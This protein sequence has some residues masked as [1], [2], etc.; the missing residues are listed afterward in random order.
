MAGDKKNEGL[1]RRA[2]LTGATATAFVFGCSKEPEKQLTLPP[3]DG[4]FISPEEAKQLY[5]S[6]KEDVKKKL[7]V[8]KARGKPL[9]IFMLEGHDSDNSLAYNIMMLNIAK[10]L[11][12]GNVLIEN[13]EQ[14]LTILRDPKESSRYQF[15]DPKAD[16]HFR[17]L[18][19]EADKLRLNVKGID[20]RFPD[21]AS[22][23]TAMRGHFAKALGEIIHRKYTVKN[24]NLV[25]QAAPE[26][27]FLQNASY[28]IE[29]EFNPPV[30]MTPGGRNWQEFGNYI[31]QA[32]G[33]M[34]DA[35]REERDKMM[36]DSIKRSGAALVIIGKNH[37]VSLISPLR[38]SGEIDIAIS[39]ADIAAE[40]RYLS[41]PAVSPKQREALAW[42]N[43]PKNAL[44]LDGKD[45]NPKGLPVFI[46][47]VI[48]RAN[49]T[50]VVR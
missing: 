6:L 14:T 26:D 4:N 18:L 1:S 34:A 12:I 7:E 22:M 21:A 11:G 19:Q 20:N 40:N 47:T 29:G 39:A 45:F 5:I 10:E 46:K 27:Q 42:A 13:S 15:Q 28:R 31:E 25:I 37:G 33:M 36:G 30:D 3:Q 44:R 8:A 50:G 17:A 23:A 2:F 24:Y 32:K 48:E 49:N 41:N 35:I 9:R 16:A 38:N 43:N